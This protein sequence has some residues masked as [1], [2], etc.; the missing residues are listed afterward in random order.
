[1][2]RTY[3]DISRNH[4]PAWRSTE[5]ASSSRRSACAASPVARATPAEPAQRV[6]GAPRDRQ[7]PE[8]LDAAGEPVA[9]PVRLPAACSMCPNRF[10]ACATISVSPT[11]GRGQGARQHGAGA[12][13]GLLACTTSRPLRGALSTRRRAERTQRQH[14][15]VP[16][17]AFGRVPADEPDRTTA[18]TRCRTPRW[19]GRAR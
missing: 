4:G 3:S 2:A 5:V 19:D 9:G 7:G 13:R 11:A 6:P 15:F 12:G 14:L 1:M 18:P 16:P 10:S 8:P 17:Q